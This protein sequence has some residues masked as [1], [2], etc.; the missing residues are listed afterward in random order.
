MTAPTNFRGHPLKSG[1]RRRRF[2]LSGQRHGGPCRGT[3]IM[4]RTRRRACRLGDQV[5]VADRA[6]A[7]R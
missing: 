2:S 6:A 7:S 4:P 3:R 5:A 1:G